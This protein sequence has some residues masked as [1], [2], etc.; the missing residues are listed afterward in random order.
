ML[1]FH[2]DV[3]VGGVRE[4]G[5]EGRVVGGVCGGG[6][7]GVLVSGERWHAV[8]GFNAYGMI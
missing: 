8:S 2:R 5:W 7:Q 1:S 6:S 3:G 4:Q